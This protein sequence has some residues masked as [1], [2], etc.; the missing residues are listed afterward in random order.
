M[1]AP[2]HAPITRLLAEVEAGRAGAAD[3]LFDIV[4]E[5]LRVMARARMARERPGQTIQA[6]ALVHE[7]FLQLLGPSGGSWEN[8]RHFFG[9]AAEAMRRHFVHR[10]RRQ[11]A[12]K[13]GGELR[14]VELG[15]AT[16]LSEPRAA[17][18]LSLD[19]ALAEL[20]SQ[21]ERMALVIKLR[22]F[23]G[24]TVAEVA[25]TMDVSPRTVD[26]IWSSG[27]AWLHSRLA[28]SAD[29]SPTA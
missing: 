21:D 6:T 29:P 25:R 22:Y 26:R 9:A 23:A 16:G 20:E 18:L 7:V 17:E 28:S 11:A 15:E 10:A 14:R 5:E 1:S 4:Y 24:L 19:A 12:R 8:R 3:E 27:R 13:H 2:T